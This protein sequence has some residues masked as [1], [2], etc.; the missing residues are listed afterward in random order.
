MHGHKPQALLL[1]LLLV[2]LQ[3]GIGP[4]A[5]TWLSKFHINVIKAYTVKLDFAIV[6][7]MMQKITLKCLYS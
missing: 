4:Q 6:H 3:E 7:L 2:T 5:F 1:K